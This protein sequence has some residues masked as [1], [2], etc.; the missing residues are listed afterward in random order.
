MARKIEGEMV[1]LAGPLQSMNNKAWSKYH[2]KTVNYVMII[3][4]VTLGGKHLMKKENGKP[5]MMMV[6]HGHGEHWKY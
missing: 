6:K 4:E 2:C 5:M 3:V 1:K